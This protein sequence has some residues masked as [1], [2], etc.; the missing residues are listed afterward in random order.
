M[1]GI[2]F[3]ERYNANMEDEEEITLLV[4]NYRGEVK[5][6]NITAS[7][8]IEFDAEVEEVEEQEAIA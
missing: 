8:Q 4:K 6:V 1:A 2:Y 5:R 3:I 7:V